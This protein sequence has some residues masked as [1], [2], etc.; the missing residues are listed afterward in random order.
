M[1][2]VFIFVPPKS[3]LPEAAS[4]RRAATSILARSGDDAVAAATAGAPAT[5]R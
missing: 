5:P 1:V 2:E 4:G 3:L